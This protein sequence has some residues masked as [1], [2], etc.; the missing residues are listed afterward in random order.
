[1]ATISAEGQQQLQQQN[2]LRIGDVAPNFTAQ[3]QLGELTLYDYIG[4]GNWSIFFSHPADFTPV[5]TTE[6]GRVGQLKNEWAKRNVKV[7]ALSVDSV[8][9][10][11]EWVEDIEKLTTSAVN[12]PIVAD[13]D[14]KISILY[15]MLDATHIAKTGLPYTV[16][17]V[18]IID[19]SHIIR[20]IITYPAP[21]GR[22]FD[23]II[24]VVDSLQLAFSHQVATP[25]DWVKGKDTCI[26]PTVST[27]K[28]KELF[29]KGVNVLRPWFRITPDPSA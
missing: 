5:C 27:E 22:N 6:L 25:A 4:E 16:R 18:F 8:E 2:A 26:L 23:E 11:H 19:P 9:H 10:H 29:P 15:G 21:T 17:S 20:T 24:R 28:A 13:I 12:F 3:T 1:M 7:L 14:R